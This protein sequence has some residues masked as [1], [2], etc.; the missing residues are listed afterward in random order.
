MLSNNRWWKKRIGDFSPQTSS[1]TNYNRFSN[2][3][4][5]SMAD[6]SPRWRSSPVLTFLTQ[7]TLVRCVSVQEQN[8]RANSIETNRNQSE[9]RL[10]FLP[11]PRLEPKISFSTDTFQH[12]NLIFGWLT[13]WTRKSG[14]T[15]ERQLCWMQITHIEYIYPN[16]KRVYPKMH[17]WTKKSDLLLF[18]PCAM[19]ACQQLKIPMLSWTR[20]W[21]NC[22]M[23]IHFIPFVY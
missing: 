16:Q 11:R 14:A 7:R 23:N 21:T 5:V 4:D 22:A 9:D 3:R 20:N 15:K 8:I 2:N 6:V 18:K 19:F 1:N 12:E 17:E 10:S 13:H